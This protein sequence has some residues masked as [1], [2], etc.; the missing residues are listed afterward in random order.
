MVHLSK[1]R[2]E[3]DGFGSERTLCSCIYPSWLP[4]EISQAVAVDDHSVANELY[5]IIK[6]YL[7]LA[8][9]ELDEVEKLLFSSTN[10]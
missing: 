6:N 7:E 1:S 9:Q 5:G 10:E 2:N 4:H 8:T 3:N